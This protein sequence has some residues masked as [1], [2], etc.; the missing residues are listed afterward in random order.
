[1]KATDSP[2]LELIEGKKKTFVIPPFQRNYEWTEKQCIELFNDI[3]ICLETQKRHYLGNIVYY[4][5]ENDDS[6]Y[7]ELILVDGQQ[8]ITTILLLICA[9][10][11]LID[12]K[13]LVEDI[14]TTYLKNKP[15]REAFRVKLKQTAYDDNNFIHVVDKD[16]SNLNEKSNIAK[17]YFLFQR[18]L[19]DSKKSPK[20]IL[21]ALQYLD[22]IN[23][24]LSADSTIA[25]DTVQKIFEKINSTGRQLTAA[26]LIRNYLLLSKKAKQQEHLYNNYWINIEK[27]VT[28]EFISDFAK[29]YLIMKEFDDIKEDSVYSRFKQYGETRDKEQIL[30]EM[31]HLSEFYIWLRKESCPNFK[32]NK[33]L[34]YLNI[35][36]TE[37]LYPLTLFLFDKLYESNEKELLKI[38]RLLSDFMLRYRIVKPSGGGGALSSAIHQQLLN[39]LSTEEI[40]CCYDDILLELSNS[41]TNAARFPDDDEFVKCLKESNTLNFKYARVALL[42]TEQKETKNIPVDIHS[43]TIEHLLPQTLNKEWHDYYGG[44][45]DAEDKHVR[46]LN[47]IGNLTLMSAGYNSK[48]SNKPWTFKLEQIKDVQ[49]KITSEIFYK[50]KEWNEENIQKRNEDV[51]NRIC[52]ATISPIERTQPYETQEYSEEFVPGL[53]P[54]SDTTTPMSGSN[55]V[56]ILFDEKHYKVSSWKEFLNKICEIA[57]N[58]DS[59]K[60]RQIVQKNIIHKSTSKHNTKEKDP[61]ISFDKKF[62]QSPKEILKTG[63]FVEGCIS[64]DRA[65]IYAKMLL[66]ELELTHL[67]QIQVENPD[68]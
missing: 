27:K 19:K 3:I 9:I 68:K 13:D 33:E 49:F 53:Y 28:N 6:I 62:L 16:T 2:I 7:N 17:N 66:D 63:I 44:V 26:D 25:L 64:S 54:I 57:Y 60:F 56:E 36:K 50:Y 59:S 47:C 21:D 31:K 15:T 37:V 24:N 40:S 65:R 38:L 14:E 11:D 48:N 51:A 8:R 4:K 41:R 42:K 45:Q 58:I 35:L 39:K 34:A 30:K 10:R 12:D 61:I 18:L 67:C 22:I 46:Y 29:D 43:V 55:I 23:V 20:E 32:I 52:Q 5:G 1:M